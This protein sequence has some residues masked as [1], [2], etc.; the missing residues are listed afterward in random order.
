M[1]HGIMHKECCGEINISF[2]DHE[3][4]L[5]INVKDNG[6]GRKAAAEMNGKKNEGHTS[7]GIEVT[8]MRL[9]SSNT[10]GKIPSG[11]EIVDLEENGAAA[12]TLVK[13]FVP[14]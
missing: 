8:N 2:I 9:T 14:Q 3:N 5:E 7:M 12:G 4:Y 13:I 6:I 10:G 1:L 11:V